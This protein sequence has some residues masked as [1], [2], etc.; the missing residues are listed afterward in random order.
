M[1]IP[2]APAF[3][4]E[5]AI[6]KKDF[7]ELRDALAAGWRLPYARVRDVGMVPDYTLPIRIISL[8]WS[9]GWVL[10]ADAF[11]ELHQNPVLW[12]LALRQAVPDI[13]EN[14]IAHGRSSME[15][16]ESGQYPLNLLTESMGK[17]L[18]EP[19]PDEDLIQSIRIL[20][21]GGAHLAGPYPGSF[22]PGNLSAK[23]HT[24]WTRSITF[25][26]WGLVEEFMPSSWDEFL[27]M[28]RAP[29]AVDSLRQAAMRG[30]SGARRCWKAWAERF[31]EPW[32]LWKKEDP[33]SSPIEIMLVPDLLP[34]N[35]AA[36]WERWAVLDETGWSSLHDL[37]VLG[38]EEDAH[39][40]LACAVQDG[41]LCLERW[42]H[43]NED[44]LSPA[45]LWEM[46]NGRTSPSPYRHPEETPEVLGLSG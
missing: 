29:E 23:G 15:R 16:L 45:D 19:V 24:L 43:A 14:M 1:H 5:Q 9:E 46:A 44:G 38:N 4:V 36:V 30:E 28:P 42:T 7:Q 2:D 8:R 10:L 22:T 11:P 37:A 12:Q 17:T 3:D 33:F 20:V 41:A 6:W 40:V 26:R 27:G 39:K 31:L 34:H 13:L 18:G 21:D 35:R 32:L 25:G